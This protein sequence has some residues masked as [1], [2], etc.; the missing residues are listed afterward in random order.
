MEA[1]KVKRT[2]YD[3]IV[4]AINKAGTR[5]T[6]PVCLA[7]EDILRMEMEGWPSYQ[8]LSTERKAAEPFRRLERVGIFTFND[9]AEAVKDTVRLRKLVFVRAVGA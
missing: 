5:E 3:L 4:Q 2:R 9:M 8:K 1:K 6:G 7:V